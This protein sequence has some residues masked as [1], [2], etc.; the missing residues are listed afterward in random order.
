M[1]I[2]TTAYIEQYEIQNVCSRGYLQQQHCNS[3]Y[4]PR[5]IH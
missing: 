3:V 5:I 4:K 2:K 1:G